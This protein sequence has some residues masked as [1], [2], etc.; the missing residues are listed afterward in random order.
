MPMCA[1]QMLLTDVLR[2]EWGFDGHITSDCGVI[3][4]IFANHEYPG[5]LKVFSSLGRGCP[6]T[7]ANAAPSS[8]DTHALGSVEGHAVTPPWWK[9]MRSRTVSSGGQLM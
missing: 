8:R 5:R 2:G 3:N 4:D 1:N 7:R 9:V 6:H